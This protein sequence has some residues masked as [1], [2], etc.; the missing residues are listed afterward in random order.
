MQQASRAA[1]L[2]IS[3]DP[4]RR[5]AIVEHCTFAF[6]KTH[7]GRIAPV[8]GAMWTGGGQSFIHKGTNGR[9]RDTLTEDDIAAYE[10]KAVAELGEA[11]ARW[12]AGGPDGG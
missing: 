4:A 10:A 2:D 11:G 1:F 3:I 5:P 9:W 12:L 8:G 6:M 7:A